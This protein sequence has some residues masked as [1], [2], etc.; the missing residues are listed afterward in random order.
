[1]SEDDGMVS[2]WSALVLGGAGYFG[3]VCMNISMRVAGFH[4]ASLSEDLY[5]TSSR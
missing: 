2:V 3:T 4:F 5:V 1:M